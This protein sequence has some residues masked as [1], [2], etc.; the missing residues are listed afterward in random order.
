FAELDVSLALFPRSLLPFLEAPL[1]LINA[2]VPRCLRD[3]F[4][5]SRLVPAR[6]PRVAAPRKGMSI[7]EL[8]T[9]LSKSLRETETLIVSNPGIDFHALVHVH[10]ILGSND[11]FE[12]LHILTLHEQRHQEQITEILAEMPIWKRKAW[13]CIT[14]DQRRNLSGD[15]VR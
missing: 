6:H 10:P 5:R 11:T 2:F 4:I 9:A 7:N 15:G 14:L 12:L 13:L 3:F 8:R 1:S